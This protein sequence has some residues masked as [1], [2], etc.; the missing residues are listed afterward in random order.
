MPGQVGPVFSCLTCPFCCCSR[1]GVGVSLAA[2]ML[3]SKGII[4]RQILVH[5][6]TLNTATRRNS[7]K[8][9]N[10]FANVHH[11][12]CH[13]STEGVYRSTHGLVKWC[14]GC[15]RLN[16]NKERRIRPEPCP[17]K[18][19]VDQNW[20]FSFKTGLKSSRF[21]YEASIFF[22]RLLCLAHP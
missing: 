20:E 13:R 1:L 22:Q 2:I 8:F 6:L 7:S 5:F 10:L 14:C 12:P 11:F 15:C 9:P 17:C 4:P 3:F 16:V 21:C 18:Q 19:N